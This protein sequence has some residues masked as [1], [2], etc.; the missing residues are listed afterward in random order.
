MTSP[1][2]CAEMLTLF[3]R[4]SPMFAGMGAVTSVSASKPAATLLHDLFVFIPFPP[5][6]FLYEHKKRIPQET[7]IPCDTL[8]LPDMQL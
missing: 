8:V 1:A 7:P 3:V 6:T 4:E 2:A 5:I